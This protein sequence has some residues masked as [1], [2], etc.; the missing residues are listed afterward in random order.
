MPTYDLPLAITLDILDCSL[1]IVQGK[2]VFLFKIESLLR[3]LIILYK[4]CLSSVL[5]VNESVSISV[6]LHGSHGKFNA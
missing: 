6:L 2:T 4:L 1:L 5:V 3:C